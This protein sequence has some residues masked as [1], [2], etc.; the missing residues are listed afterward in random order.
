MIQLLPVA[1]AAWLVTA[2]LLVIEHTYFR[3][4]GRLTRY[5]L[6]GTALCLGT[7]LAGIL[8]DN[9]PLAI[10]P[11]IVLSSGVVVIGMT[12]W[13]REQDKKNRTAQQQGEVIG[14]ARRVHREI[15]QAMIDRGEIPGGENDPGRSN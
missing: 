8:S 9:A 14:M 6:G 5:I 15:S 7:T 10:F 3:E 13:E 1:L 2:A 12:W 4:Q 11:W